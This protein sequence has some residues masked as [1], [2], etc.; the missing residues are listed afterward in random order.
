M[1]LESFNAMNS[2]NDISEHWVSPNIMS[3]TYAYASQFV[4]WGTVFSQEKKLWAFKVSMPWMNLANYIWEHESL[5]TWE[6]LTHVSQFVFTESLGG[7]GT[8]F[9]QEKL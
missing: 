9:S 3:L 6:S 8:M 7:R 2:A 1:S 4:Y 5:K